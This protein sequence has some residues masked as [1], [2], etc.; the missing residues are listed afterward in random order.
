M[1]MVQQNISE[2]KLE[3]LRKKAQRRMRIAK[4]IRLGIFGA[5]T[6]GTLAWSVYGLILVLPTG[7]SGDFFIG[8]AAMTLGGI[9]I[10]FLVSLLVYLCVV[11]I[12]GKP[13][14]E[15]AQNYKNKYVLMKLR[16]FPGF[17]QLRYI[18]DQSLPAR[19]LCRACLPSSS[20][21]PAI[22]S[23]DYWEGNY[24]CIRF[25]AAQLD[26][27]PYQ[28]HIMLFEGQVMIFSLFN[29]RK[30]SETPVQVLA[31]RS[32]EKTKGLTFPY[33]VQTENETFN[34]KFSVYAQDEQNAFY[35]LTPRVMED[36]VR[37][38][39]LI[40]DKVYLVFSGTSLY[41]GCEQAANPFEPK[42]ELPLEEQVGS[43]RLAAEMVRKARDILIHLEQDRDRTAG[44]LTT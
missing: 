9:L 8:L 33:E 36:I 14:D 25:R 40:G 42:E 43:I 4:G 27:S 10:S 20:N 6:L 37:F 41:V 15:F 22:R 17:S 23:C 1:A 2:V 26:F 16:E 35:I 44:D 13:C 29:E 18:S 39:E 34:Q 7:V 11:W 30:V 32:G 21:Q 28:S 38:S 5:G 24:D 31:K 12:A 19:E 3:R